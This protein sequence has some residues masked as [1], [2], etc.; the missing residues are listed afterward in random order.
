[1]SVKGRREEAAGEKTVPSPFLFSIGV[2]LARKVNLKEQKLRI[3]RKP[4]ESGGSHLSLSKQEGKEEY[5]RSGAKKKK[6]KK[7]K[8]ESNL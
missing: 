8:Y 1:L 3:L 7:K 6:K 5:S 2:R 4:L